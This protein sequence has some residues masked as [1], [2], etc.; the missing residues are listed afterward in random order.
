MNPEAGYAIQSGRADFEPNAVRRIWNFVGANGISAYAS[1]FGKNADADSY[2]T[3]MKSS[4]PIIFQF[5]NNRIV[6]D[7]NGTP[8]VDGKRPRYD[9]GM[10]DNLSRDIWAS[11][12]R[13]F[14][15]SWLSTH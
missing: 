8:L 6:L 1:Y 13:S 10:F 9:L 12:Y 5:D 3:A 7:P 15:L 2:A 14:V 4:Y 11:D